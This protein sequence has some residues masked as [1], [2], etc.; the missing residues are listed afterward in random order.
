MEG[1]ETVPRTPHT[2]N[3]PTRW[4]PGAEDG[5]GCMIEREAPLVGSG[6]GDL[7]YG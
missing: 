7:W 3:R 6:G 4:F 5:R 2:P 1:G